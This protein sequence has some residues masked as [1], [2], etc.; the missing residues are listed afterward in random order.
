MAKKQIKVT[1]PR[2]ARDNDVILGNKIR[3]RRIEAGM[4]QASLGV[5]LGVSF[6]QVQKYEK[7]VNRVSVTRLGQIAQAL[8]ESMD[9][10]TGPTSAQTSRLTS[11]LTDNVT[12][13]LVRAFATIEDE[14]MKYKI[15]GLVEQISAQAA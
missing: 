8:G 9:Y 10:F 13:R 2:G 15:V 14:P 7:G 3:V 6:Q 1:G 4:S 12:Q 11:L 5:A